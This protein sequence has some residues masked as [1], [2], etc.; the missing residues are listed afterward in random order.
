M[1]FYGDKFHSFFEA[2]KISFQKYQHK[3]FYIQLL[4]DAQI[5]FCIY[6]ICTYTS[7]VPV[8]LT[9]STKARIVVTS[10]LLYLSPS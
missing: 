8:K 10:W 4:V 1:V 3:H 9:L 5:W 2:G 7:G 6:A